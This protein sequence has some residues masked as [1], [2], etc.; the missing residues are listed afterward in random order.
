M[1]RSLLIL[2][3][4]SLL[5]AGPASAQELGLS[6]MYGRGVHA[7]FSGQSRAAYQYF[8]AAID[9]GS[10]DPRAYYFRGL[11]Y[12]RLGRPAEAQADFRTGAELEHQDVGGVFGVDR[13]LERV[14]GPSRLAIERQRAV[15]RVGAAQ[16]VVVERNRRTMTSRAATPEVSAPAEQVMGEQP[17]DFNKLPEAAAPPVRGEVDRPFNDPADPNATPPGPPAAAPRKPAQQNPLDEAP[18][19]QPAVPAKPAAP[20]ASKPAQAEPFGAPAGAAAGEGGSGRALGN[21]LKRAF[22]GFMPA[23]PEVPAGLPFGGGEAKPAAN[24]N[25]FGAPA[26]PPAKPAP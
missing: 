10:Q 22:G 17:A 19:G 13:A 18:F 8:T 20:P 14:Q 1:Q 15:A 3:A 12:Q 2:A 21:V 9:A 11:A 24:D 23:V 25:P 4:A 26:T 7:Y 6:D 5:T 16:E